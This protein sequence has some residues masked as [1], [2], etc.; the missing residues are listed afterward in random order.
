MSDPQKKV[1]QLQSKDCA[2]GAP[3]ADRANSS[4]VT[5]PERRNVCNCFQISC[6]DM[7]Q[8][9]SETNGAS[10]DLLRRHYQVGTRCTSCEYEIK[11]MIKV[12]REEREQGMLGFAGM[13]I[14]LGRRIGTWYR[15]FK[16]AI[17]HHLTLRRFAIFVMRKQ[18]LSTS[19][20]LSNLDF[21]EDICNAN[22]SAV[23]FSVTLFDSAGKRLARRVGLSLPANRSAEYSLEELF[24]DVRDDFFG[25]IF[26]DFRVLRQVGSLR[27]YCVLNFT[28]GHPARSGRWHYHDKYSLTDYNGHYHCNHPLPAGQECWIALSNPVERPYRSAVHLRFIP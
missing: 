21:P 28:H 7:N 18:E 19:L 13:G 6:E 27:P 14:P 4:M 9:L 5:A 17:L 2:S 12:F 10:F 1:E 8:I 16:T 26:V 23:D 3:C 11:D 24:P 20:V 22:G 25:M 15:D